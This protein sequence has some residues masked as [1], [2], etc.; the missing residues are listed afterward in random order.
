MRHVWVIGAGGMLGTALCRALRTAG[1]HVFAAPERLNWS[2]ELHLLAQFDTAVTAF[3]SKV[4]TSDQ[5]EIYWAAGVGTMGGSAAD[6]A[7]ETAA[8]DALLRL[9]EKQAVLCA[10][11]GAVGFASSAGAI[12]AGAVEELIDEETPVA[13][14]TPYAYAKLQQE[15]LLHAF[16]ERQTGVRA[17]VA[18][19]STLYGEGQVSHK[20]QGLLSHIARSIVRNKPIQIYVPFDTIRDYITV[21]DAALRIVMTLR[22]GAGGCGYCVRLVAS[23][24]PTTIAEIVATFKRVSRRAPRVVTSVSHNSSLYTRRVHFRSLASDPAHAW[25]RTS[26]I[27]GIAQLLQAERFLFAQS[28]NS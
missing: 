23:E 14:T 12:Y 1:D 6:M 24:N 8:L 22:D 11:P 2:D 27:V 19:I 20:K 16:T 15:A 13:P 26:L 18:R 17:L 3:S 5:W 9:V 25:P 28:T 7:L 21:T 4:G 10:T